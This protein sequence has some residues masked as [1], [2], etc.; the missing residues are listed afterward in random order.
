MPIRIYPI[1]TGHARIRQRFRRGVA[2]PL[3][4]AAMMTGPW[5]EPVPLRAWA[6]E[7]HDGVV[8]VDTGERADVRDSPFSRFDVRPEDEITPQ[9][10]KQGIDPADVHTVVITHL[11]GDHVNG[12]GAFP[13]ARVLVSRAE[14][15]FAATLQ[16]RIGRRVTHQTLPADFA[17]EALDFDGPGI[18]AFGASHAITEEGNV[19]IVPTPGHTPGHCAVLVVED[20][21]HRLIAG[22]SSYD[23]QQL[24]DVHVDGVSPKPS[25]AR[26]TM[27]TIIRHGE[28]H[29]TVYLP[30]HDAESAARL[31]ADRVLPTA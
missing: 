18:G 1:E 2:G 24:L 17:P 28:L 11:H 16:A 3:R 12:V 30:T 25:L 31:D 7:L 15:R 22:D 6:I 19:V 9:L 26:E 13:N 27:R 10:H 20:D 21:L 5:T 4:Q 14:L 8:M 23:Q 29:P